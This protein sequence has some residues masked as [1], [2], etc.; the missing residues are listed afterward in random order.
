MAA[1]RPD[2]VLAVG[3][4]ALAAAA[5]L[6]DPAGPPVLYLLAPAAEPLARGHANVTGVDLEVPPAVTLAALRDVLPKVRRVGLVHDPARTAAV[7]RGAVR[8]AEG[9]GVALAVL[10]VGSAREAAARLEELSGAVDVLWLLP[11]LTVAVP[12]VVQ[13]LVLFSQ[14]HRVPLLAFSPAYV[15]RGATLAVSADPEAM[16]G[17][18]ARMARRLLAGEP[19][20]RVPV[21]APARVV[22]TVNRA[23]AAQLGVEPS[24]ASPQTLEWVE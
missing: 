17:Q 14:R 21:E 22:V 6:S 18:A 16:A 20:A 23:V 3:R 10:P 5:G 7:V 19:A 12:E 24:R 2:L 9:A 1:R 13:S 4:S 15:E 8:A 11:D